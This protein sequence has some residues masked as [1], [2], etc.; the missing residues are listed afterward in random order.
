MELDLFAPWILTHGVLSGT[1][2]AN[3]KSILDL[4]RKEI[5]YF[6]FVESNFAKLYQQLTIIIY[7]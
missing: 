1:Y 5:F 2:V 7:I 3:H 4:E 6:L